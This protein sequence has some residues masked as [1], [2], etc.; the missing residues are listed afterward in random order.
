M[1]TLCKVPQ[2]RND[3]ING[4]IEGQC[5]IMRYSKGKVGEGSGAISCRN[6]LSHCSNLDFM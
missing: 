2:A 1:E 3:L 6:F 5:V 4:L